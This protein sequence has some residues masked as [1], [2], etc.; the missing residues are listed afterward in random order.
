MRVAIVDP[1]DFSPQYNLA[2]SAAIA[3]QTECCALVGRHGFDETARPQFRHDHFYAP[4]TWP[5]LARLPAPVI[6]G[7]KG[8]CHLPDLWRL[9]RWLSS[10]D[11]DVVHFQWLP[12][13]AIDSLFARAWQHRRAFIVTMHDSNPYNG[14]GRNWMTRG[15][16]QLL[17]KADAVIVH[18]DQAARRLEKR[19]LSGQIIRHVP[20]GLLH[21][22]AKRSMRAQDPEG[23]IKLLQFGKIKP[24]KGV[25]ILIEALHQ[26]G[27]AIRSRLDIQVVGKPY[28][29]M[30]PLEARIADYGLR[31]CFTLDLGYRPE[32]DIERLFANADIA[33]FPYR[34]IDASGVVMTAIAQGLPVIASR[35][36][37]FAEMFADGLGGEL[38]PV[39]DSA[40]LARILER[41]VTDPAILMRQSKAI[42]DKRGAIPSWDDIAGQ[43]LKIY[44]DVLAAKRPDAPHHGRA[45]LAGGDG[46]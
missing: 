17:A 39:E 43:T 34:E 27:P 29:D 13:P 22:C 1:G 35:A 31:D 9:D 18:T 23:R 40:A 25:D 16:D 44:S 20:H 45:A 15:L 28:M 26:L 14:V 38:F 4:V 21:G 46:S 10:N 36:G 8:L 12:L 32:G 33:L 30:A 3:G 37:G 11:F 6:K 7:I 19:G 2:L 42:L 5:G 24:Y 41:W